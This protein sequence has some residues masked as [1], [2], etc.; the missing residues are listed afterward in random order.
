MFGWSN[1]HGVDEPFAATWVDEGVDSLHDAVV[2]ARV[3]RFAASTHLHDRGDLFLFT[4]TLGE[5]AAPLRTLLGEV[6]R[7]SLYRDAFPCRGFYLCGRGSDNPTSIAFLND[8]LAGKVFAERGLAAPV[9]DIAE[10]RR[11]SSLVAQ[12]VCALML[13]VLG[14]GIYWT[15]NRLRRGQAEFLDLLTRAEEI[16][17]ERRQATM[18]GRPLTPGYRLDQT[19]GLL[20]EQ[21]QAINNDGFSWVVYRLNPSLHGTLTRIFSDIVLDDFRVALED[22]G[23]RVA[24]CRP[25]LDRRPR[26]QRTE[27]SG[28]PA[29]PGPGAVRPGLPS[30]RGQLSART[31]ISAAPTAPEPSRRLTAISEHLDGRPLEVQALGRPYARALRQA[32]AARIDCRI[33]E[34]ATSGQSLV[35]IEAEALLDEFRDWTFD[36][37][38]PVR[39]AARDFTEDW[40][41]VTSGSGDPQDLENLI[42]HTT[43]LSTATSAW[44]TL[45][46]AFTN[47]PLALF[48]QAPFTPRAAGPAVCR[49]CSGRTGRQAARRE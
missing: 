32:T 24:A 49:A 43:A 27:F 15:Y 18:N 20:D 42:E 2:R 37:S 10:A 7:P 45:D 34:D 16:V 41:R 46:T 48:Q 36:E 14:F 5:I 38:N 25:G 17:A 12:I 30:V 1:P 23:R 26:T 4:R 13:V 11:R 35:A 19:R 44:A 22:K 6:F 29:I 33:F 9:P 40:E 21:L 3:D 31:T 47:Q 28:P 8:L 39:S